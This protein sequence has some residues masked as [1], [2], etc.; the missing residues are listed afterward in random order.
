MKTFI[1]VY[2]YSE[3]YLEINFLII[4]IITALLSSEREDNISKI[5]QSSF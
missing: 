5:R 1:K 2:F 3:T 4:A